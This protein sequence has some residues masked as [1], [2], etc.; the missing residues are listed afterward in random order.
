MKII[1]RDIKSANMFLTEDLMTIKLGDLGI[2]KHAKMDFAKTQVGTPYYLA[3]EIWQNKLYDYRCD[4][5]SLGCIV[6]E[7]AALRVPFNG[8]SLQELYKKIS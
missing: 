4:I 8:M 2:A 7:M 1:H 5:F 6:Y 3:P